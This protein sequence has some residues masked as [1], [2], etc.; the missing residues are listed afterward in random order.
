MPSK[1]VI[2]DFVFSDGNGA[3]DNNNRGDFHVPVLCANEML[4]RSRIESCINIYMK[5]RLEREEEDRLEELR[6][7]ERRKLKE[8]RES[9]SCGTYEETK[10]TCFVH[11]SR[12]SKSRRTLQIVLQPEEYEFERCDRHFRRRRMESMEP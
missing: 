4:E 2:L 1:A 11:H 7:M 9:E 12:D 3:Y 6:Q 8:N 10:S 5:L